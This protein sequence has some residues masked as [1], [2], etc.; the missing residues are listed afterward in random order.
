MHRRA[1]SRR[2]MRVLALAALMLGAACGTR[3]TVGTRASQSP[4]P[5][6][7]S[8]PSPGSVSPTP[9]P[10]VNHGQVAP[11][12]TPK[13]TL[14][15][16][17]C[18]ACRSSAPGPVA[19]G[20]VFTDSNN[21]QSVQVRTGQQFTVTLNSTYWAFPPL[22]STS[23]VRPAGNPITAPSPGCIPGGGC[24]TVS[25][26]Y[27]AVAAGQVTI[28]ATRTSCGEAMLCTGSAG[29]YQLSVVVTP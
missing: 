5:S 22:A 23:V 10:T 25:A 12:A 9:N 3:T 26:T 11:S 28:V 18:G 21:G 2:T 20:T 27:V 8:S 14:P 7:S 24:G 15:S 17:T 29:Q 13:P 4:T 6:P 16:T 19:A 1:T